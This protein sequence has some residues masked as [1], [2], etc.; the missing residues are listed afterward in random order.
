MQWV[1]EEALASIQV[2]EFV[3]L[4]K[5]TVVTSHAVDEEGYCNAIRCQDT[6]VI[7]S[8]AAYAK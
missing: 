6:E 2:A 5:R 4:P 8:E 7:F 1:R 3:E